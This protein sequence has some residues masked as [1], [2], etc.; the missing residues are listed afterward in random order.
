VVR[1][2]P[3]KK[4]TSIYVVIQLFAEVQNG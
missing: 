1:L 2:G 3:D 4:F